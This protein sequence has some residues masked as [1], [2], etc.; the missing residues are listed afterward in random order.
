MPIMFKMHPEITAA[1][2]MSLATVFAVVTTFVLTRWAERRDR[3]VMDADRRAALGG[4]WR[5]VL[6]QTP[7]ENSPVS[8]RDVEMLLEAGRRSISGTGSFTG[9][10]EGTEIIVQLAFTGGFFH[11]RFL[12]LDYRNIVV[13]SVQFGTAV[14]E[15][16]TDGKTLAGAYVGFGSMSRA[17]VQG[18]LRLRK[19]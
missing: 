10:Y 2:I 1:V 16:D 3:V 18:K 11:D 9:T 5:G 12:K 8:V 17:I 19:I 6:E 13:G 14:L 15:L 4:R 7:V